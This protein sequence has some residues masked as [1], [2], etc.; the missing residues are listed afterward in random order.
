MNFSQI[1]G[2]ITVDSDG[3]T[4]TVSDTVSTTTH[5]DN[6]VEN[7]IGSATQPNTLD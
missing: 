3:T 4:L 6:Q 5:T 2:T 1:S 7:I